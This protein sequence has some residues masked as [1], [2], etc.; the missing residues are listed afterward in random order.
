MIREKHIAR[1]KRLV[2]VPIY[3]ETE[4]PALCNA[5]SSSRDPDGCAAFFYNEDGEGFCGAFGVSL[6]QADPDDNDEF[7]H[8]VRC[9]PC[10]QGEISP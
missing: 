4:F 7:A 8:H 1:E 3:V 6:D 2:R 5:A 9:A 10:L